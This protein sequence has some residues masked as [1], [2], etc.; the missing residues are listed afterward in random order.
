MLGRDVMLAAGNAGHD[1]VGYG[2]A[3]LDVTDPAALERRFDLERPDVVINCAAWTDVDGAEEA[4]EAAFADQRQRR[5]QRRRRRRRDRS[6]RRPR[7]HRLRL[8]RRQGRAL[9]GERPAGAALGLRPHQAGRG[10]G[11]RR[12]QQAPLHRPLGRPLRDRRPQLR[13]D[14]AAP[15]RG[16]ERGHRRPRPGRLADLHLAPRLRHR[17]PDRGDRVRHPPH[18]GGRPVLLVRVR[19]RD[20][21]AG[22]GR[23]Q[24]ALD[25]DRGI[26]RRGA[27]PG[28]LGPGQPARAR[29]PA[30][31]L[32]GR[33]GRLS[34]PTTSGGRNANETSGHRSGRV[35]RLHLRAA[36]RR[37]ARRRRPRQAHLRRAAREPARGD[38]AGRGGDRGPGGRPRSDAGRRRGRQLRRRVPRRPLDRRPGSLRPH[39]RDRHRHPARRR[40]RARGRAL[41]AGLHRR[42]LRL[43]RLRLLHRDLA[44]RPLL[45][46]LGDQGGR[47][48]ARLRPLSTPTAS[49]P[50]SSAAPTTTARAST[51]RS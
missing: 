9:R 11:G 40:P 25:H 4:E 47:R 50:R 34:R 19:P 5:R 7:L 28:L 48:P 14:D 33:P 12:R 41:P 6:P 18:G 46:L 42:G 37:R 1:V 13:R 23:V 17:P 38:G 26:R 35:H 16:P 45:A 32:A 31:Q 27:A 8:R 10:G 43:D 30:A 21:R 3:E 49:T 20:L 15:G 44:A 51:R 22:Q 29:D 2:R 24:S 39:P 36:G